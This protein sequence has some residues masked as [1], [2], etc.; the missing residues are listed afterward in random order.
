M[1][2]SKDLGNNLNRIRG[3]MASS[4]K[5]KILRK[6]LP[7]KTVFCCTFNDQDFG[8]WFGRQQTL[9]SKNYPIPGSIVGNKTQS[10]VISKHM[11]QGCSAPELLNDLIYIYECLDGCSDNCVCI[12]HK[13]PCVPAY[14]GISANTID[15]CL[16][17]YSMLPETI[18]S[19]DE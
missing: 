14:G 6:K 18:D 5:S 9:V 15:P 19:E 4:Q 10:L 8:W 7:L 13:Q 2:G 16:S 1:Y 17:I 11:S 12:G 3:S